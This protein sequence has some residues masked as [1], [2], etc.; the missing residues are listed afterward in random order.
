MQ[1]FPANRTFAYSILAINAAFVVC[2]LE[3]TFTLSDGVRAVLNSGGYDA[4]VLAAAG[5]LPRARRSR[6]T[7]T[8][9]RGS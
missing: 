6:A 7:A 5:S 8:G 4:I 2:A 1:R 9:P 3:Y